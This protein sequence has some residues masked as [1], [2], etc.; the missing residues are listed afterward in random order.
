[1]SSKPAWSKE[2]VSVQPGL[3]GE[4]TKQNEKPTDKQQQVSR[5]LAV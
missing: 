4:Q 2:Q 1:M 3:H 5:G